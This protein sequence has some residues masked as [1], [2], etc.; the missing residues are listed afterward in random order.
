M[1]PAVGVR[2]TTDHMQAL[3]PIAMSI[4]GS[5]ATHHGRPH[6]YADDAGLHTDGE[7]CVR[8]E[9]DGTSSV[10]LCKTYKPMERTWYTRM[11]YRGYIRKQRQAT[12]LFFSLSSPWINQQQDNHWTHCRSTMRATSPSHLTTRTI[13]RTFLMGANATSPQSPSVS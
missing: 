2:R 10:M 12:R 3:F 7:L 9:N 5:I 1:K 4:S 11:P 6:Q 13:R 8:L